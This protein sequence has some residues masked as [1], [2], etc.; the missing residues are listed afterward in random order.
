[1]TTVF[2]TQ[3]T[4][5]FV[6]LG[7]SCEDTC[8]KGW[9]MQL[10]R[11]TI[12]K[13]EAHAPE[14]MNAVTSG[15]AEFVMKRDP[16]TDYCVKFD[17]GWCG[18]HKTYGDSFLGD[19]C[20]FFPRVTRAIGEE[21]LMSVAPSC[22]QAARLMLA[23]DTPFA[24]SARDDGRIPFS[25]KQY[26]EGDLEPSQ[27]IALHDRFMAYVDEAPNAPAAMA[28][29]AHLAGRLAMQP[30]AQWPMAF[31]FYH[32]QMGQAAA[33]PEEHPADRLYIIGALQGLIKAS[34]ATSRVRLMAVLEQ[35]ARALDV[36]LDWDAPQALAS[37][38]TGQRIAEM[39]AAWQGYYAEALDHG[40]KRYIQMQLSLNFF[41]FSGLGA[42][43]D[44]RAQIIAI[45]FATVQQAWMSYCMNE[46]IAPDADAQV[47]MLQS[48]SRFLDHLADP[49]LSLAIY[50]EVG[51]HREA[52]LN[53]LLSFA[54]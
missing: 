52:R 38:M 25:I 13:Y 28:G 16:Q 23:M 19:A 2:Q 54:A 5:E 14:L 26:A 33:A 21:A 22:P 34:N 4:R 49:A 40:L 8:C 18:I 9:G 6:C 53:A 47:T 42:R 51:W 32:K 45:R 46:E 11:E 17:A 50:Q 48:I 20:H 29:I 30:M 31:D 3:A 12:E 15:E 1:M 35:M 10:T 43:I 36:T 7:D 24:R 41:P 27:M 39:R 37:A 44:N